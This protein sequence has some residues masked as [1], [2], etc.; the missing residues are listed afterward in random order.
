MYSWKKVYLSELNENCKKDAKY[1]PICSKFDNFITGMLTEISMQREN[2]LISLR[3]NEIKREK[4]GIIN[5]VGNALHVLF[6]VC[7]DECTKNVNKAL[8]EQQRNG[9]NVL[10]L[11]KK[12]TTLVITD[13]QRIGA[14]IG[15]HTTITREIK[16]RYVKLISYR[17][18][19]IFIRD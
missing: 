3:K 9:G 4:R 1:M 10:H 16:G 7:D 17:F 13:M 18:F 6:G 5:I 2:I 19:Y 12:Q 8:T 14:S 15:E 11:M